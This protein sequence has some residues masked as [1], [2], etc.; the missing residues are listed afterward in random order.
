MRAVQGESQGVTA[1]SVDFLPGE[2]GRAVDDGSGVV[3]AEG[4]GKG[5]VFEAAVGVEDVAGVDGRCFN[6]DDDVVVVGGCGWDR[7]G[8][9]SE[10]GF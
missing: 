3:A 7:E 4:A 5:S 10:G 1:R 8:F 9:E 2:I 6:F